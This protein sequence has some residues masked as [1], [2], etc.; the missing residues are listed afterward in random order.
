MVNVMSQR[1]MSSVALTHV[2]FEQSQD[3]LLF[4]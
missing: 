1:S 4:F 3:I 2:L